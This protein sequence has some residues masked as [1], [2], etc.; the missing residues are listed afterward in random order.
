MGGLTAVTN[1]LFSRKPS[2]VLD[3]EIEELEIGDSSDR[4][5]IENRGGRLG[6]PFGG[7]DVGGAGDFGEGR[8]NS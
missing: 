4:R 8:G 5:G 7:G 1:G 6:T 3:F 2:L